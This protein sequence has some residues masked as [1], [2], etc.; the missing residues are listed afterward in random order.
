MSGEVQVHFFWGAEVKLV[1]FHLHPIGVRSEFP[2]ADANHNILELGVLA[3]HVVCVA[4]GNQGNTH[5]V[6]NLD[7]PRHLLTLDFDF[8]I[9]DLNEKS[10]AKDAIEPL[11]HFD[12]LLDGRVGVVAL[13]DSTREFAGD[14]T[15]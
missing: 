4:G 14:T 1:P 12:R 5:S 11:S 13:Q 9:H 6:G 3:I 2:C 15:A 10:I 8:V 7:R